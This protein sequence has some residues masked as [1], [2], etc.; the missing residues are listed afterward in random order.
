MSADKLYLTISANEKT[1]GFLAVCSLGSPQLGDTDVTV[2]SIAV[3]ET[4]ME[5]RLWF[6]RMCD[7]RPWETRQ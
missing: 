6:C 2:C 4:E 1:G 5:A 3:V 7:E